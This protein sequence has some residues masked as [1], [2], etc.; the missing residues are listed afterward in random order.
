MEVRDGV[1]RSVPLNTILMT[2]AV[3]PRRPAMPEPPESLGPPGM[4]LGKVGKKAPPVLVAPLSVEEADAMVALTTVSMDEMSSSPSHPGPDTAM[5][6][7]HSSESTNRS[8]TTASC[9]D[10]GGNV[11]G[12]CRRL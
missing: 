12:R 6:R 4:S 10:A 3:S 5:S 11:R 7:L 1:N 2:D 8:F 9:I